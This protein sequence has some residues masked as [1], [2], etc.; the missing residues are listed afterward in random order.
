[1]RFGW[2]TINVRNMQESLSFY[3]ELVGLQIHRRLSPMPGFE[4]VF[5]GFDGQ[6]TEVELI[7]HQDQPA[8]QHG[9]DLSLGFAVDS[10]DRQMELLRSHNIAITGPIQPNPSIR[11]IY[12]EDPN[13]VKIQFFETATA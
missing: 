5:L 12:V 8:P 4:L 9:K 13:G 10:L 7:H 1:M 2:V 11:F 3:T 6:G